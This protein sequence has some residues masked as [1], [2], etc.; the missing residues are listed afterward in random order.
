MPRRV[1]ACRR[2]CSRRSGPLLLALVLPGCLPRWRCRSRPTAA[3][4]VSGSTVSAVSAVAGPLARAAQR[5]GFPRSLPVDGFLTQHGG[6]LHLP[7]FSCDHDDFGL[8]EVLTHDVERCGSLRSHRSG[9]HMQVFGEALQG[10]VAFR[11]MVSRLVNAFGFHMVDCW[12]NLYRGANDAKAFH[13]DNYHDRSPLPTVTL[14]LSL[15]ETRDLVFRHGATGREI[16]VPQRNGDI[17]AFDDPFNKH[18]KHGVPEMPHGQAP[19]H[20]ISVIVWATEGPVY[21]V[22]RRKVPAG[23]PQSVSWRE[24][25]VQADASN[26][27]ILRSHRGEREPTWDSFEAPSPEE[28]IEHAGTVKSFNAGRG[29]G[30]IECKALYDQYG[31]DVFIHRDHLGGSEVGDRVTFRVEVVR[32]QPQARRVAQSS[33]GPS[34][35]SPSDRQWVPR[36]RR[37]VR[38]RGPP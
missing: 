32:G 5:P 2:G 23:V 4:R 16:R 35:S 6:C 12:L 22:D 30:F 29:F 3:V 11:S 13:Y 31:R 36:R 14:G 9:K 19:G 24:F 17:F 27:A 15:G 33:A 37:G 38:F 25:D 7:A 18:F 21:G 20:R 28:I 1:V 8:L 34:P 26:E 10:S